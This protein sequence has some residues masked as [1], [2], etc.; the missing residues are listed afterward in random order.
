MSWQ[1]NGSETIVDGANEGLTWTGPGGAPATGAPA[2]RDRRD[3]AVLRSSI[4]GTWKAGSWAV[5]PLASLY[6]ADFQT[7]QRTTPGYQNYVDRSEVVVGC[8]LLRT[9]GTAGAGLSYR[10]GRQD[11]ARLFGYPEEYD[12]TFDRVL[13]L[14]EG[15]LAGWL[16]AAV[17]AGPE[18]RR[19]GHKVPPA[20]GGR[21]RLTS[22]VDATLTAT[23][24]RDDALVLS[25]RRFEMVSSSGRGA[26]DDLNLDAA[27]RHTLSKGAAITA[28]FHA[29]NTA[30]LAPTCRDDWVLT[31]RM[32]A[33]FDLA[34]N[35]KCDASLFRDTA[36]SQVPDTAGREYRRTFFSMNLRRAF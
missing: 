14:V 23:A 7:I 20:L 30:F 36:L 10:R 24:G 22:Y 11:Q 33:S 34:E 19:Y 25:A 31:W 15:K 6:A 12:N 13:I 28:G 17:Q 2:L 5:R 3:Q 4:R 18:F 8:D 35:W 29:Y 9:L 1:V 27:W 16:A 26:F 21:D 32:S